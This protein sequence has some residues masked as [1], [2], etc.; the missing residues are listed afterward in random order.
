[1]PEEWREVFVLDA[2][3]L[4]L[5]AGAQAVRILGPAQRALTRLQARSS[6]ADRGEAADGASTPDQAAVTA[7]ETHA[8]RTHGLPGS[9]EE[10]LRTRARRE[11]AAVLI[12]GLPRPA[13]LLA[14]QLTQLG[15]G[16]LLLLDEHRVDRAD[17]TAGYPAAAVGHP[18]AAAVRRS[19]LRQDP[20]ARVTVRSAPTP[21]ALPQEPV[22]IHVIFAARA[23][24]PARLSTAAARAQLVLPVVRHRWDSGSGQ[25]QIGPLLSRDHGPCPQC[26]QLHGTAADPHWEA[27][28]TALAGQHPAASAPADRESPQSAA[29]VASLL[30]REIQ[31]A[32]D[33]AITPQTAEQMLGVSTATGRLSLEPVAPHPEC[34]CRLNTSASG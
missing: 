12:E 11:L 2:R 22:D 33:G 27:V 5:G 3:T 14:E 13:A 26:L 9:A 29:V 23:I 19:C 6:S 10:P 8:W 30:A 34:A 17:V 25:W 20:Q 18:R 32:V 1:M 21:H 24:A 15:L 31:L 28:Q 16:M 7:A 4:Q